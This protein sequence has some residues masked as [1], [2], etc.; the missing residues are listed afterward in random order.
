[1]I[2]QKLR[3]IDSHAHL[4]ELEDLE[5]TL[6]R[7]KLSG[8]IGIVT[9]GSDYKSNRKLLQ[10]CKAYP[11]KK[12]YPAIFPSMG[13]HP[14]SYNEWPASI[15]FIEENIK[16]IIAVGEIGLDHWCKEVRKNPEHKKLQNYIFSTQLKLASSHKKAVV[17]HC[18]G[19]WKECLDRVLEYRIEKAL[20]HWYSGPENVLKKLLDN[21]YFISATP[22]CEYSREHRNAVALTPIENL[23]LET[24]SPVT[25]KPAAGNYISEPKDI[26]RVLKV[27][28]EIKNTSEEFIAQKTTENAIKFFGI[29]AKTAF[30]SHN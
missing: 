20:F 30:P 15:K 16:M 12:L 5:N 11:D 21:G 26:L 28:A 2:S 23:L 22:A 9:S 19:A 18:R 8:I 4:E 14:V 1:M 7:A 13:I 17:I 29:D 10:I 6:K 27:V 25:Y 3:I 24:D